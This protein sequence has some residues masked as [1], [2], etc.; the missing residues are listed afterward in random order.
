MEYG[1]SIT[2]ANV[3]I[4]NLDRIDTTLE[5]NKFTVFQEDKDISNTKKRVFRDKFIAARESGFIPLYFTLPKILKP[6]FDKYSFD[7]NIYT[8]YKKRIK[9]KKTFATTIMTSKINKFS[10][11]YLRSLWFKLKIK[12]RQVISRVLKKIK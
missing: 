2:G 4:K 6:Y 5:A 1:F 10:L 7:I 8:S 3:K 11:F 12:L 9:A